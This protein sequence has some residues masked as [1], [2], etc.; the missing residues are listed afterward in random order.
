[1]NSITANAIDIAFEKTIKELYEQ[2]PTE[3]SIVFAG[4]ISGMLI[5][6]GVKIAYKEGCKRAVLEM[7][8]AS[9]I[10]QIY[11]VKS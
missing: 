9:K 11:G 7:G 8:V 2:F 6:T 1:M 10:E 5:A 3:D 4:M